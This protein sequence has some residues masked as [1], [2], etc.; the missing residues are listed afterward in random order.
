MRINAPNYQSQRHLVALVLIA[1][2]TWLSGCH[3][4]ATETK[5]SREY[6]QGQKS[7]LSRAET[8]L[9]EFDGWRV[10][11]LSNGDRITCMAIKPAPQ[12]PK[13][14]FLKEPTWKAQ[15]PSGSSEKHRTPSGGAGFYMYLV[16]QS[17][18]P[19]FGFYGKYPFQLPSIARQNELII[20]DTN[21]RTTVLNW[22]GLEIDFTVTT[23]A[24]EDRYDNP[25]QAVGTIDFSGVRRAYK[26]ISTC[27][28]R[29]F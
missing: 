4:I 11:R 29:I 14:Q 12:T 28:K 6:G 19:Y 13:P 20:Y 8:V 21:D 26:L 5:I 23:Q 3:G 22:E 2:F 7:V 9:A 1:I 27:H 16:N 18:Q 25:H 17:K 24:A 10:Y 15:L